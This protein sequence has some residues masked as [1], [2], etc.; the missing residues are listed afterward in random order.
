MI[1]TKRLGLVGVVALLGACGGGATETTTTTTDTTGTNDTSGGETPAPIQCSIPNAPENEAYQ[2]GAQRVEVG[3]ASGIPL[4]DGACT[5]GNP[6]ACSELAEA[7]WEGD[8][9]TTDHDRAITL[10]D[11]A[12]TGGEIFGCYRAG[13]MRWITRPAE[14]TAAIEHY[15]VACDGENADA[16]MELGRL[17]MSGVA[18]GGIVEAIAFYDQACQNDSPI[19]CG[20]E[21]A[22]MSEGDAPPNASRGAELLSFACMEANVPAACT[23]MGRLV[24]STNAD[25]ALTAL[26]HGCDGHDVFACDILLPEAEAAAMAGTAGDVLAL[27]GT[28]AEHTAVTAASPP[29]TMVVSSGGELDIQQ[30]GLRPACTGIVEREADLVV[31]VLAGAPALDLSVTAPTDTTLAVRDPAGGWHCADDGNTGSYNPSLHIATPAA[32]AWVVWVG[33]FTTGETQATM[34]IGG[35]VAPPAPATP[36]TPPRRGRAP[37]AH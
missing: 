35:V 31:D 6:C 13:A 21:G 30:M 36:P 18:E 14:T 28:G 25:A 29:S 32:G 4:L 27:D 22:A 12:C 20:L 9:V 8:L 1:D 34:H 16:C 5:A 3:D 15:H 17:T 26:Q 11:Q 23:E 37:A 7:Y 19:A 33:R 24:A 10:A 2:Q